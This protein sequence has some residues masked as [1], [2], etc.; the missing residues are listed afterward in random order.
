MWRCVFQP[1]CILLLLLCAASFTAP[2]LWAQTTADA[3]WTQFTQQNEQLIS[4]NVR[5]ILADGERVW[6]GAE[7]GLNRYDGAWAEILSATDN[8]EG[9][10]GEW[11]LRGC[12]QALIGTGDGNGLWAGTDE[13]YVA[14]WDG[15]TWTAG[16]RFNSAVHALASV[17]GQLWVGTEDGLYRVG[18]AQPLLIEPV[19]RQPVY[20]LRQEDRTLWLGAQNGL[21]RLRDEKWAHVGADQGILTSG[22]YAIW[23]SGD[24]PMWLGTPY[25]IVWRTTP[26]ATWQ[27]VETLDDV[28]RPALVQALA[29]DADGTIWAGTDGAGAFAFD[30]ASGRLDN[31]GDHEIATR[32]VRDLAVDIDGSIWFATPAGVFRFQAHL[33]YSDVQ[34]DAAADAINYVNDLMIDRHGEL[35]I[36]TGGAGI[37]RKQK[38]EAAEQVYAEAEGAPA[39][40]LVLE[41]GAD[42]AVWAGGF[43]GLVRYG[44][45]AWS[46]PLATERLPSPTV[47]ALLSEADLLWIGTEKGLMSYQIDDD[48]LESVPELEGQSIEA[49]VLDDLNRLWAGTRGNGVWLRN[50]TDEWRNFMHDPN[51]PESL[52]GNVIVG[53]GM[54]ADPWLAGGVWAIVQK[55][56]LVRWNGRRWIR[57]EERGELPSNLLWTLESSVEDGAL[58]IGS[59]AGVAR[60]DGQTW[61]TLNSQDGL[62]SAVVYAIAHTPEGG[63][64]FGGRNGLSYFVPEHTP[65][66]I[67]FGPL[68]DRA[69][70]REDG[71]MEWVAGEDF[72]LDV[73]AGDLQ[74][75]QQQLEMLMRHTT[76]SMEGDWVPIRSGLQPLALAEPGEHIVEFWA[77]DQ[78]FNYADKVMLRLHAAAPPVRINVPL[79]G[80]VQQNVFQIM[81]ILATVAV[82][83]AGYMGY[84]VARDWWRVTDAVRRGFNPY[85]SGEPIRQFDMFYGRR[86][87]LQRIVDTLH[88]NSIMIHGERRMGKTTLLY[89]LVNV[90]REV[91][92]A[93]YWFVPVYIDLEGTK[94]QEFFHS[95]MEEILAVVGKLPEAGV[96]ILPALRDLRY[97][98]PAQELYSDRDFTRDMRWV[99]EILQAYGRRLGEKQLRIILLMDEMD[100]MSKYDPLIQQQLRR[101]FM[102]EFAANLGAVVAGIQ[103]SK[104][105]ERVESPWYNLFNEIALEPFTEEQAVE[106]LLE[107][108]RGYYTYEPDAVEFILA[109]SDGRPFRIQQ[110]GLEAVNHML[111]AKRR[112]VTLA[113]V[114]AAHRTIQNGN[115]YQAQ[116]EGD[117]VSS[118]RDA[119]E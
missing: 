99:T 97:Y 37:R 63:Y 85:I 86:Q 29:G 83:G 107:P 77:R 19:G 46:A 61:G 1:V 9:S 23:A 94:E 80:P 5:S 68:D 13:G 91:K 36:A 30:P 31:Y 14:Q 47:T 51:D 119:E 28:E 12:V 44:D 66:W 27:L 81:L 24:G 118:S 7:G 87:L 42:G 33:W 92:D 79:L 10:S 90:L 114:Q 112:R 38:P 70:V 98:T 18:E 49:L 76:P 109:R 105:W 50:R 4:N 57:E 74:S 59:E 26:S 116:K 15:T 53:S 2:G 41:E 72:I 95:L 115:G 35:W 20:A 8:N 48:I 111:E 73:E 82:A 21:W 32:F 96:E 75:S 117:V 100:V 78:S 104:E 88:N 55:E 103:I 101:I 39:T 58:W 65:P 52:P 16:A 34:T 113:D 17:D 22:V 102:R 93:D 11:T 45:G 3:R 84:E 54:A 43:D 108:V 40:V 64:W 25:G 69:K 110:Y 60:Y 62:Q 67:R 6:F 71:S 89:Q 56:G 106:L